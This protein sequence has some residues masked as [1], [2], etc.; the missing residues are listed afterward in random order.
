MDHISRMIA[1]RYITGSMYE[2]SLSV[3]VI[4]SVLGIFIGSCALALVAAIMHGFDTQTRKQ[5]QAI[6]PQAV[7]QSGDPIDFEHLKEVLKT[8]FPAVSAL[9]PT[10][11]AFGLAHS[12]DNTSQ[13]PI[14]VMIEAIDPETAPQVTTLHEKVITDTPLS[15][16]T[17]APNTVFIG[18]SLAEDLEVTVGDTIDL[19][20][21]S[22]QQPRNKKLTFNA[23]TVTVAGIIQTGFEDLDSRLVLCSFDL[24][25]TLFPDLGTQEVQL[26]FAPHTNIPEAVTALRA[27]LGLEVY[28]W[29]DLYPAML[30]ALTLEEYVYFLV[31]A[32]ITLVASM[33]ILALLFM[34]ITTKRSDIALLKTMGFSDA[35]IT[36]IFIYMGLGIALAATFC[37][38]I[39]AVILSYCI[40]TYQL[41]PLPDAYYVTHVPAEMTPAIVALVLIVVTLMSLIATIIPT[42]RIHTMSVAS[43]LRFEG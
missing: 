40:E 17:D 23:H 9:S 39:C 29:Q 27:R 32:L 33:N 28:T 16:I 13:N 3:M 1:W 7:I 20:Y 6:H 31:I 4:I 10:S 41:I 26:R 21:A 25:N 35:A 14:V 24:L 19:L 8:E 2:R 38:V 30:A 37:G 36:K 18:S 43:I 11:S 22:D 15:L 42:R 5:M 12:T 34:Q